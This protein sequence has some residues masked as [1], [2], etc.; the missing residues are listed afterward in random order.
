MNLFIAVSLLLF[1]HRV[2]ISCA[3]LLT[4]YDTLRLKILIPF[5]MVSIL[6][7]VLLPTYYIFFVS[8]ACKDNS[9]LCTLNESKINFILTGLFLATPLL[10]F[11]V[12]KDSVLFQ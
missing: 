7:W 11:V 9:E 4:K 12:L 1:W 6:P 10:R 2:L 8:C 3:N 5:V